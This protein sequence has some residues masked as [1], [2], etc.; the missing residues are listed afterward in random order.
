[1]GESKDETLPILLAA[2]KNSDAA[3]RSQAVKA[4]WQSGEKS[5]SLMPV[6]VAVLKD[7]NDK[8]HAE[9]SLRLLVDI[10]AP[11]IPEMTKLLD[12]EAFPH[13]ANLIWALGRMG[14]E[15][16]DAIPLL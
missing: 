4:L 7:P 5:E 10:G 14:R 11:A 16:R 6:L 2:L 3:L 8:E 1:M 12:D 9:S 15:A 13:R